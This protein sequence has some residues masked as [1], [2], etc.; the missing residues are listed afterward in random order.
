MYKKKNNLLFL[1]E[2]SVQ[3]L[4]VIEKYAN[5]FLIGIC[6]IKSFS[7]VNALLLQRRRLKHLKNFSIK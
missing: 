3:G 6:K 4:Q 1:T 2:N 5:Y 7:T